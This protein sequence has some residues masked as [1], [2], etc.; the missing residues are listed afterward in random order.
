VAKQSTAKQKKSYKF[1]AEKKWLTPRRKGANIEGRGN[2]IEERGKGIEGTEIRSQMSEIRKE[3][4]NFKRGLLGEVW[5]RICLIEGCVFLP[6][7]L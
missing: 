2:G 3:K 7:Q 5:R 6:E 4:D 1:Q